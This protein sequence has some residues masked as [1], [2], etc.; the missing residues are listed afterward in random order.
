MIFF[1]I[2]EK[3]ELNQGSGIILEVQNQI[4][5]ARALARAHAAKFPCEADSGFLALHLS[6]VKCVGLRR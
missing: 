3:T 6:A 2:G 5:V 1:F 4:F